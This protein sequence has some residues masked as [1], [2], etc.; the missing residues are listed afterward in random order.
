MVTDDVVEADILNVS[1]EGAPIS[2][3]SLMDKGNK[4]VV[5]DS[6]FNQQLLL[7]L[8][9]VVLSSTVTAKSGCP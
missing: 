1:A 2:L 9:I 3:L 5:D 4:V 7:I 6:N 8:L